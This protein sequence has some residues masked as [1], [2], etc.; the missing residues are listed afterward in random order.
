MSVNVLKTT[1]QDAKEYISSQCKTWREK[2]SISVE[3]MSKLVGVSRQTIYDFE[4]G[5]IDSMSILYF[6][7][8]LG[9]KL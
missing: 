6:Y 2:S 4:S 7:L 1:R 5:K 9:V 3:N 8:T